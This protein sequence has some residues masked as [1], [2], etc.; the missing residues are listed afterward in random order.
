MQT[1]RR[2]EWFVSAG[3]AVIALVVPVPASA[4]PATEAELPTSAEL[5]RRSCRHLRATA[6]PRRRQVFPAPAQLIWAAHGYVEEEF[7]VSGAAIYRH[8]ADGAV[9]VDREG[10][11]YA[12]R[13][14]IRRPQSPR[15]FSG[16]VHVE[17]SHPQYG[18]NVVWS[19]TFDYLGER[20]RVRLH[21]DSPD[22]QWVVGHRGAE[23]LRPDPLRASRLHRG[24]PELGHHRPGRATPQDRDAGQPVARLRRRAPVRIRMVGRRRVA[25]LYISDGFH[26][27]ARMPDGAP[28]FDG[29][30]V[31]E[32]SPYPRINSR[33]PSSR[34]ATNVN[35]SSRATS[36]PSSLHTHPRRSTGVGTT[37]T[38]RGTATASTRSPAPPTATSGRSRHR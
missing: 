37:A 29:Y 27:R 15:R 35:R 11:P 24:R 10:V 34:R 36:L 22:E 33:A 6:S 25:P 31:G 5:P 38:G 17:T 8:G 14:L 2:T 18:F 4:G 16:N 28:I 3:L 30:L 7:I 13:I 20:R 32:P 23:G 1:C 12:T 26:D 21:H 19:Q 9:E